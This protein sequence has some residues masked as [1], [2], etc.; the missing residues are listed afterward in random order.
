MDK[1]EDSSI[2]CLQEIHFICKDTQR[3]KVEGK[4]K[5]FHENANQKK[6]E[7]VIFMSDKIDFKQRL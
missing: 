5:M 2:C 7:M 6:A 1:K 4:K 3:L